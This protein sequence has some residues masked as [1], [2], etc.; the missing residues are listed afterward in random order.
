MRGVIACEMDS[1]AIGDRHY[2]HPL[3]SPVRKLSYSPVSVL[4]QEAALEY[5]SSTSSRVWEADVP[6]AEGNRCELPNT[7]EESK[8]ESAGTISSGVEVDFEPLKE[9]NGQ[10]C[11]DMNETSGQSNSFE[12]AS[13]ATDSENR[14]DEDS[15]LKERAK[16]SVI[17]S[18]LCHIEASGPVEA[19][20]F[21][22]T[23]CSETQC[24]DAKAK[25]QIP[26][27]DDCSGQIKGQC[28]ERT[29]KEHQGD[30]SNVESA[31][32]SEPHSDQYYSPEEWGS[33]TSLSSPMST[34]ASSALASP[35]YSRCRTAPTGASIKLDVEGSSQ[36]LSRSQTEKAKEH[37]HNE[38]FHQMPNPAEKLSERKRK[39]LIE[40]IVTFQNDGTVEVDVDRSAEIAPALFDLDISD[41][42]ISPIEKEHVDPA[43]VIPQHLNIAMLIVGTRGDV[44][45]F[46]A[47]G[48]RLKERGHRV[49]LATHANFREFVTSNGLE[50]YPLGGDPKVLAG[51]MVKNKGFLPS[52]PSEISIQKK[53]LKAIMYS[54]LP[55]CT[56]SDGESGVPFRA[57]AI[58]ANPPA[59]GHVHVAEYLDVPLHIFFTMPW[60]PTNEFPHPLARVKR[61]AGYRISYL[62]VDSLMWWGIRGLINEFRIKKLKLNSMAYFSMN[63]GSI[64]HL[65]TGYMWS[66]HLVP[67]PKDWGPRVDVVGY[68]F[69]NLASDYKPP[70]ALVKWLQA[71]EKPIYVGFGSL[72][73][74]D[75]RRMTEVIVQALQETNQ[76]GIIDKGWG[77]LG[78][79]KE[80]P[81]FIFLLE[82]CPHDWLFP[83]CAAVVH[84]GG[85]GTTA[86]GLKSGCPTTIVPFFGDQPFWGER[87]HEKGVGP[88]PIPVQQFS[89]ERLV[90]A[91]NY[92]LDSEVK[93]KALELAK[94]IEEEDGVEGAVGAF[95]RHWVVHVPHS[96]PTTEPPSIWQTI[97]ITF[98]RLNC[99]SCCT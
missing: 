72:P 2:S 5:I 7:A 67:K 12:V 82:N 20:C 44:Q 65:P 19:K 15:S 18:E 89:L 36:T 47:I 55:A 22:I 92:M 62:V 33:E 8:L 41:Q 93:Q 17:D 45:P 16:M 96:S 79:L 87:V 76:R 56:E 3:S 98:G 84:H 26:Q 11:L 29:S 75:P 50:F 53:Q 30:L 42:V 39:K 81:D 80:I 35:G 48:K 90:H 69:L 28:R 37:K 40:N 14:L 97:W 91:I 70:D 64:A 54:L 23:F 73:V 34:S 38:C 60:T 77:G 85:A 32:A 51:Y 27:G 83:Q 9:V 31:D 52:A 6:A 86:A 94:Q 58:I 4:S 88:P 68:C 25:E 95:Y 61:Q 46:L 99:L 24:R 13:D 71:G 57:E 78:N 1:V 63:Q 59:Y 10:L 49:R 43:Q 21:G 66:P 74:E